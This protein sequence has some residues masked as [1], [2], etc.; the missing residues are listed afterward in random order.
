MGRLPVR[1]RALLTV[2]SAA[3]LALMTVGATA[4]PASASPAH[5]SSVTP[6]TWYVAVGTQTPNLAIQ[7]MVFLP[8]KITIDVGDTVVWYAHSAEPHTVTFNP[9]AN[10]QFNPF[11]SPVGNG[12]SFD[13][14]E[15]YSSA[16]L[17]KVSAAK[18]GFPT[19]QRYSLKFTKAG[20]YIYVCLVH[21]GMSGTVVV[22]AAGT[23]YPESQ[24]QYNEQAERTSARILAS[25][26]ALMERDED[27]STNH[28]VIVGDT[29]TRTAADVMRYMR[30]TV[31]IHAGQSVTFV[32]KSMEPHTVTLGAE[33]GDPTN[34]WCGDDCS[35]STLPAHG[36]IFGGSYS[37]RISGTDAVFNSGWYFTGVGVTLTFTHP[38]TYSYH[39]AL[40][41]YMGMNGKVIVLP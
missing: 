23:R 6:R 18:A 11:A 36:P 26:Y 28:Y 21:P 35:N 1:I 12:Q 31:V 5:T 16:A 10:A 33:I 22:H 39:C 24:W 17:A 3:A 19:E 9:A 8:G 30:H 27:I 20:T 14:S 37:A 34:P 7:G 40:H 38:G 13:G 2:I 15:H 4:T 29:N 32:N 25:G 41:D